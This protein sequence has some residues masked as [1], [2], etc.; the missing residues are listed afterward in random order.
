VYFYGRSNAVCTAL[1]IINGFCMANGVTDRIGRYISNDIYTHIHMCRY[2]CAESYI[3]K[4]LILI[5]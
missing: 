5:A 3:W 4:S 2:I 1:D